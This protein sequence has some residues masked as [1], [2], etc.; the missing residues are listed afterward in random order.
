MAAAAAGMEFE[1]LQF[2]ALTGLTVTFPVLSSLPLLFSKT[3]LKSPM[4]SM[5]QE[6]MKRVAYVPSKL[7]RQR[8]DDSSF[9]PL[10]YLAR[11]LPLW[12]VNR[13][14]CKND[15]HKQGLNKDLKMLPGHSWPFPL[16]VVFLQ[17]ALHLD[18]LPL[19]FDLQT[20]D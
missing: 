11:I 1:C 20:R 18:A 19:L 10:K 15:C 17:P 5:V 12:C 16:L 2:W 4:S 9:C 3:T 14:F 7:I 13:M 6:A 8:S